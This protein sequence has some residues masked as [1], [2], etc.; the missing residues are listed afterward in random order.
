MTGGT[1]GVADIAFPIHRKNQDRKGVEEDLHAVSQTLEAIRERRLQ[2]EQ[3]DVFEHRADGR[4][5]ETETEEDIAPHERTVEWLAGPREIDVGERRQKEGA[6]EP[7]LSGLAVFSTA[8]HGDDRGEEEDGGKPGSE[9]ADSEDQP[10]VAQEIKERPYDDG[11]TDRAGCANRAT[12][13]TVGST[14]AKG[15]E[16]DCGRQGLSENP[17]EL[18]QCVAQRLEF[19]CRSRGSGG[20]GNGMRSAERRSGP[21][22]R[23]GHREDASECGRTMPRA[24]PGRR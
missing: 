15:V 5:G 7:D 21:D 23:K 22:G 19:D 13:R 10:A 1:V 14:A 2:F 17:R 9:R 18:D 4:G 24:K 20:A 3:G 11:Q 8:E 6:A 16:Q 12:G